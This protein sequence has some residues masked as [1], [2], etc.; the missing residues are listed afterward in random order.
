MGAAS[1]T[2]QRNTPRT[3]SIWIRLA[4]PGA[5][6]PIKTEPVLSQTEKV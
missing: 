1:T 3:M 2:L 6:M 5:T 4:P